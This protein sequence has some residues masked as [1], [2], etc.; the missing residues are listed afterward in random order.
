MNTPSNPI[1]SNPLRVRRGRVESVDLYEVK[2]SELDILE[3]GAPATVQLTF[4]VFL[5]SMAITALATLCTATFRWKQVQTVFIIV[6]VV[7]FIGGLYL[8]TLWFISRR[9]ITAVVR[10][11]RDRIEPLETKVKEPVNGVPTSGVPTSNGAAKN[12]PVG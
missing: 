3:K 1:D 11:I 9:S 4:A 7:G 5:L 8:L 2:D 6:I 12:E 10:K